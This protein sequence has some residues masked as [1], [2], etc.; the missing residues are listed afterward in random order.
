MP[1]C[2]TYFNQ[3]VFMVTQT[4]LKLIKM[5]GDHAPVIATYYANKCAPDS[6]SYWH[7]MEVM[8]ACQELLHEEV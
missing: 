7:W 3:G 5:Y 8:S 4:A 6:K 2:S 1:F